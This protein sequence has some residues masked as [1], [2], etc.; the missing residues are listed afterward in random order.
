MALKGPTSERSLQEIA[1]KW[2][3]SRVRPVR[4]KMAA[5]DLAPVKRTQMHLTHIGS[6]GEK[7]DETQAPQIYES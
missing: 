3:A 7:F 1:A 6:T 5:A 2:N 4:H